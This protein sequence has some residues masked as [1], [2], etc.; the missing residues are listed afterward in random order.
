MQ[1]PVT[2]VYATDATYTLPAQATF[3][4]N[5][6]NPEFTPD[7]LIN[8]PPPASVMIQGA[9]GAV[10]LTRTINVAAAGSM[11]LAR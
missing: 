9:G 6:A 7:G 5:V 1:D 10:G 2:L 3:A 4:T 11:R 8:I